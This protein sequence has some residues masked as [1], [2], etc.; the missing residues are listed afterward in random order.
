VILDADRLSP[1]Q[2]AARKERIASDEE[3][4]ERLR[5]ELD[6]LAGKLR[7]VAVE[8]GINNTVALTK[9]STMR[10]E[11]ID[12]VQNLRA[13]TSAAGD[14]ASRDGLTVT[15]AAKATGLPMPTISKAC[16][17][18]RPAL[19][20]T[21][22]GRSRRIQPADL[23]EWAKRQTRKDRAEPSAKANRRHQISYQRERAKKE[24]EL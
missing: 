4:V 19:K 13:R 7:T 11:V 17:G 15:E 12:L 1:A 9:W 8:H 22:A 14:S 21:G 16:G 23:F 20:S 5:Q 24:P 10:A 2:R 18:K 6:R 3:H